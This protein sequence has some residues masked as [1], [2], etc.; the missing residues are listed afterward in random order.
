[1]VSKNLHTKFDVSSFYGFWDRRVKTDG[2]TDGHGS[3]DLA[4]D[5]DH[6]CIYFCYIHSAKHII[7]FFAHL[8]AQGIKRTWILNPILTQLQ[9]EF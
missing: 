7:P 4:V 9:G 2:Q 5:P 8:W 3:I 6:E 1:M